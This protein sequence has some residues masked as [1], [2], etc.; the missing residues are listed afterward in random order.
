MGLIFS[1]GMDSLTKLI[2]D[3]GVT[4]NVY[5]FTVCEL[6]YKEAITEYKRAPF[7]II[8]IGHSMGGRCGL[9]FADA[10]EAEHIPVSLLVTI[11]PAHM[12]P[13]VPLNVERFIN[14]FLSESVLGGGDIKPVPGFQ[15]HYASV[16]LQQRDEISHITID[17]VDTLHRQ[18]LTKILELASTPAKDEGEAIPIRYAVPPKVDID[19][20]D[21]GKAVFAQPGDTLQTLAQ[22]YNVPLWSLTQI[23]HMQDNMPL[24][25]GQRIV[26]PRHLVPLTDDANPPPLSQR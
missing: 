21:S 5:E 25:T 14:I 10:L 1:R 2:T 7:P 8:L 26:V 11:D 6:V 16:D 22:A 13:S 19:L 12:S 4:A 15:G 17:K 20:W 24:A 18:L 3:A 23:N 9:M